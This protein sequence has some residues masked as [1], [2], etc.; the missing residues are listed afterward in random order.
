MPFIPHTEEDIQKMLAAI[1]IANITDLYT[2]IPEKLR[3]LTP[4]DIPEASTEMSLRRE[5]ET[6]AEKDLCKLN[7]I[8]AGAYEHHIPAAVLEICT[9]GEWMTAYTPYQAEASQGTL[10]LLYEYQS[11]MSE[12]MHMEVSNA[13][14]YDGASSLAEAILMAVRLSKQETAKILLPKTVNPFYR[15]VVKTLIPEDIEI[16]ELPYSAEHGVITQ[17]QLTAW[18][19]KG[20]TALVVPQPNFFGLLEEVDLL[21]NWAKQESAKIIAVVNPMAMSW[22]KPPGEWGGVG[23]TLACGE[24][25]SLG[26]PLSSGGPYFGFLTCKKA[27][28]RQLPGRLVGRTTDKQGKNGF[29]LTLQAREQHIRRAKATSNICTNQGL[30]VTAASIYMALMGPLGLQQTAQKCYVNAHHLSQKLE[31]LVGVQRLFK[32]KPFFHEIIL[33]LPVAPKVIIEAMSKHGI[34]A[35]FDLSLHYPEL[36][37]ALL[38]CATETKTE[39]DMN[40]FRDLLRDFL[41]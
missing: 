12:L 6:R 35:G 38:L 2:E 1:G 17:A 15:E 26:I 20:I 31:T 4:P 16:I 29:T 8:G 41:K 34:Q 27:D 25:Q 40:L 24:G 3:I 18:Q 11:M 13:S 23:A 30:L 33:Q 32:N 28:I 36:G 10:Q 14:L 21:S 39:V 22:L 5:M 9:R 37:N 19:G 7:F